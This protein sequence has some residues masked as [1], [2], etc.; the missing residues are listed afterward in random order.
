MHI[1]N[2]SPADLM[3]PISVADNRRPRNDQRC[4]RKE[5]LISIQEVRVDGQVT[6]L[7]QI[8][9]TPDVE[10]LQDNIE[11]INK[12]VEPKGLLGAAFEFVQST[13]IAY[14]RPHIPRNER[15]VSL[16]THKACVKGAAHMSIPIYLSIKYRFHPNPPTRPHTLILV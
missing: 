1:T 9:R 6:C 12:P 15:S 5:V 2:D 3:Y 8:Q 16:S 10:C 14:I 13:R 11:S 4:S 7:P